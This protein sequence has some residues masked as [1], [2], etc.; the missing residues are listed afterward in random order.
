MQNTEQT[1]SEGNPEQ[2]DH[3]FPLCAK[4]IE[5]LGKSAVKFHI[6]NLFVLGHNTRKDTAGNTLPIF[7]GILVSNEPLN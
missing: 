1:G 4:I 3:S 7:S 2:V 6:Q 5:A